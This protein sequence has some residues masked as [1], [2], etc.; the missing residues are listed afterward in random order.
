MRPV[1]CTVE[2]VPEG[3]W[4][5]VSR[6]LPPL[7]QC[8]AVRI[9]SADAQHDAAACAAI[10]APSVSEGVASLEE[11]APGP[12]EF[13]RRIERIGRQLPWLV[14]QDSDSVIGY[15]YASPH[16]ERAA[17]RWSANVTVYVTPGHHRR[18]IA[19]SLYQAL[20]ARL[21]DQGFYVA[22]AGITL[23]NAASVG[24][25]ESMGFEPVGVYRNIAYKHGAWRDVGWWQMSLQLL[26]PTGR[27][28]AD[29][30]PAPAG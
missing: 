18:G 21:V 15:A 27:S 1:S 7:L 28:P 8:T 24:L 2:K 10:Y 30:L 29:P 22:C 17:Y 3:R 23:P 14:A 6:T 26:P 5:N 19:R 9:R 20:F 16:H 4:P 12:D 11:Q 25:H 13:S